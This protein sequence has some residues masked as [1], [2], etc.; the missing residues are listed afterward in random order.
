HRFTAD[1]SRAY[2]AARLDRDHAAVGRALREVTPSVGPPWGPWGRR[3]AD[4]NR[5]TPQIRLRAPD[6][7]PQ[8]VM[9]VSSGLGTACWAAHELWGSSVRHFVSVGTAA[10]VRELGERLRNG[11][12]SHGPAHF[13]PVFA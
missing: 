3:G 1:V 2:V 9:D 12:A 6:F 8:T 4:P 13:G 7:A 5:P 11:G 10:A